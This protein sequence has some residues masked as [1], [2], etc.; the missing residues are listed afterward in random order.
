MGIGGIGSERVRTWALFFPEIEKSLAVARH[1]TRPGS[2]ATV[3]AGAVGSLVIVTVRFDAE[4]WDVVDG[5][6]RML[7]TQHG[8]VWLWS[9]DGEA[10]DGMIEKGGN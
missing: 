10:G 7:A 8:G 2:V 6:L 3:R 4:W 1:L 5:Y 9:R